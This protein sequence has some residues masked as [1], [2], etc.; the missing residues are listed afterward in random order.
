MQYIERLRE[1]G[2][3]IALDDVGTGYNSLRAIADLR[4]DFI[5]IDK[6]LVRDIDAVGERRALIVALVQYAL[7]IGTAVLAEGA[8]TRAELATLID[9]GVT[10]VQG[11]V[12]GKPSDDLRGVPRELREFM[13]LRARQHS[14]SLVGRQITLDG[15]V[16]PGSTVEPETPLAEVARRF[17][18]D[19]GLTSVVVVEE[20]YARG[21]VM[22]SQLD[23]ILDLAGTAN[24]GNM[25]P[26]ESVAQWMH[27][28]VLF[29]EAETPALDLARQVTTRSDISLE[30]DIIVCR[31]NLYVGIL[32]TRT[33][34]EAA[35]ALQLNQMRYA[36]PLTGLPGRVAL[37]QAL[38]ERLDA[39]QSLGVLRADITGM[40]AFNSQYG[41]PCGDS[42]IEALAFLIQDVSASCGHP[43]DFLAH[44]GSDDFVLLTRAETAQDVC[45][46]LVEG[47]ERIRTQFYTAEHIRQGYVETTERSG[48]RRRIPLFSLAVAAQTNRKRPLPYCRRILDYLE[49]LLP[50][51]KM[52][53]GSGYLID[54]ELRKS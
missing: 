50:Q 37:D 12:A 16:R 3:K 19:S 21:L 53:P 1:Q 26:A 52:Q 45:R 6:G 2:F 32:S 9:L 47:F 22:R 35:T 43:D 38:Q 46:A 13:R 8:E 28:N 51:V 7:H 10:Y 18:K 4:P 29:A 17:T 40:E 15:L 42:V 36:S 5:K 25:L 41:L 31:D 33:L 24:V 23:Y 11:Y 39:N 20:G 54:R 14:L 44:L 49:D 34:I 27:T 30:T 48:N